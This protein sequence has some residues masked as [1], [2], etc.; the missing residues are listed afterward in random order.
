MADRWL[1]SALGACTPV[2]RDPW[3]SAAAVRAGISGFA[4]HPRMI[5]SA[6]KP[7]HVAMAPWLD[8]ALPVVDRLVSL[9]EGALDQSLL[10]LASQQ[11]SGLKL[12]LALGLPHARP[13]LPSDL[14]PRVVAQLKRRYGGLLQSAAVFS[15]GHAAGLVALDAAARKLARGDVVAC[16]VAAV[17]SYMAAESLEWLEGCDQLHGAGPYNNA[18]GFIPGEGAASCL[19]LGAAQAS[20]WGLQPLAGFLGSGVAVEGKCI[21]TDTVCIGEGLTA[22]FQQV[23]Q[24]LPAGHQVT[25]VYCDMNGEP[26]R[27]DE[28]GFACLRTREHFVA[29]TD[30]RAPADCWGD[31]GAASGLLGVTLA[32]AAGRKGYAR[33][34]L[35]LVWAS[36]EPGE[37]AAVLLHAGREG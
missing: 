28:Y 17:D 27:A 13:G 18:W 11:L 2:G 7:M 5:D 29:A 14:G 32:A 25:D 20:T 37:R 4:A 12:A 19:L 9:L 36:S 16:L 34:P 22:A 3:S 30:F 21:K 6:G 35:S 24:A 33:G 10:S 15:A 1:V 8:P 26:Y 23:L 31:V